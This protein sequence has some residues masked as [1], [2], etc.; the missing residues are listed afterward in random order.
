MSTSLSPGDFQYKVASQPE[1]SACLAK[2]FGIVILELA[3][4]I[5]RVKL[6]LFTL[7][8]NFYHYCS[9]LL[10]SIEE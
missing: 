4:T 3:T 1:K 2:F 10:Y 7:V 5:K 6:F 9:G 8:N